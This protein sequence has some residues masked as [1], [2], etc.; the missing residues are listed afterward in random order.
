VK[1]LPRSHWAQVFA[2]HQGLLTGFFRRRVRHSWDAQDLTQEVYLRLL[3]AD[4]RELIRNPE[5]YLRTVAG[6]LLREYAVLHKRALRSQELPELEADPA[7]IEQAP[8]VELDR[9]RHEAQLAAALDRLPPRW[10]AVLLMQHQHGLSYQDIARELGVSTHMVKKYVV[11]A[12][13]SCRKELRER[14]S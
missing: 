7:F 14:T 4:E 2:K 10:R 11:K 1:H 5:G 3:R 13:A 12:L 8:E 9:E 6:N